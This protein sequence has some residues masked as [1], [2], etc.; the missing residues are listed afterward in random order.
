MKRSRMLWAVLFGLPALLVLPVVLIGSSL[1]LGGDIAFRVIEKGP[2]GT[3]VGG[4]V[5]AALV[6]VVM[7]C[8]PHDVLAE[9]RAEVGND[10][11]ATR[12]LD[13]M[14]A[15]VDELSRVPD[16]VL[17]EV[18]TEEEIISIEKRGGSLHVDID[19]PDEVVQASVPLRTIRS[20][21]RAI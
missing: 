3:S 8:A 7:H 10:R 18:R 13:M 9:I 12:A 19:T 6:P 17:V 4:H 15:V 1:D 14:C 5:P 20:V 21:A 11:D 2:G 16:G